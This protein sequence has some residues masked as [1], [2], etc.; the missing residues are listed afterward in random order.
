MVLH[1]HRNSKACTL[2][3]AVKSIFALFHFVYSF[4]DLLTDDVRYCPDDSLVLKRRRA[5]I[6]KLEQKRTNQLYGNK[7]IGRVTMRKQ[8]VEVHISNRRVNF[9]WQRGIKIGEGQFG[10]VYTAV[11]TD[12][13]QMMAVKEIRFQ[14]NDHQTIKDVAEEIKIFEELNHPGLVK[15]HGVEVHRVSRRACHD[16]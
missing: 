13:G 12:S 15:Y 5:E 14:P 9:K 11:N 10:K 16:G 1:V 7:Q 4:V 8:Q 2:F 3:D 6:R